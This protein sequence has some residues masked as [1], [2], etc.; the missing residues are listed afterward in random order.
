MHP[1][2]AVLAHCVAGV[3]AVSDSLVSSVAIPLVWGRR[4]RDVGVHPRRSIPSGTTPRLAQMPLPRLVT[5]S[6]KTPVDLCIA[7]LSTKQ[8][9]PLRKA[10]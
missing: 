7:K 10:L 9:L 4:A 3:G 6:E 1:F 5:R 8:I 2:R